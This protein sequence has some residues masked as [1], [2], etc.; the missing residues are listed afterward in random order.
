MK[1]THLNVIM[2]GT[3]PPPMHGMS[4]VNAA[5]LDLLARM[6]ADVRVLNVAAPSLQGGVFKRFGRLP[7]VVGALIQFGL[8]NG[9][10]GR[11]LYMSVSGGLGQVYE[12]GFLALA[13]AKGM[14]T[15]LHHHSFAYLDHPNRLTALL[16]RLVGR[17]STQVVL[18]KG[19]GE[20]LAACYGVRGEMLAM[21][22][23]ALLLDEEADRQPPTARDGLRVV[24]FLS[25][26][27]TEKGV[28]EFLDVVEAAAE[29]GLELKARL[30]GPFQDADI[31]HRV[32]ERLQ[33]LPQIEYL[34]PVYGEDKR[35]FYLSIDVML[36]PTRYR[37]EAEPLVVL[38]AMQH[39]LPVIAFGRGAIPEYI[40]DTC[41]HVVAVD[42]DFTLEA[43]QCLHRWLDDPASFRE[44]GHSARKRFQSVRSSG[45]AA[46]QV[47][48][49]ILLRDIDHVW[50]FVR[51]KHVADREGE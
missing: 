13:R 26:L 47:L 46:W 10:R 14:R 8:M 27:S 24:G 12:L 44:A 7:R 11:P 15:V 36:F 5:V 50:P 21:S 38:E 3:F 17:A 22:N 31:E 43:L 51:D 39:G 33:T 19:M 23:A 37:N 49:G 42:G 32:C 34:G 18:S 28:F 29:Q 6:G 35:N 1:L 2:A 4:A 9:V 45:L 20:R 40:D 41:G 48:E 16:M 30:A 25:N